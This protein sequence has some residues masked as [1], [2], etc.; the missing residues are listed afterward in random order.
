MTASRSSWSG[1][2]HQHLPGSDER[3]FSAD[4]GTPIGT[5]SGLI[6][7]MGGLIIYDAGDTCSSVT[8]S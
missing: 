7:E 6:I 3:P 8:W 2:A 1:P 4:L 5:P